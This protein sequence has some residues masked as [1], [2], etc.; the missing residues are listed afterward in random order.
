MYS[1]IP[2]N[3]SHLQHAL[4]RFTEEE[5]ASLDFRVITHSKNA[6]E[7]DE[8]WLPFLAW[9]RS[10]ADAEGWRFAETET[11][12]RNLI[13]NYIEIH[14]GKGTPAVIRQLFRDL[15]LGEIDII[16]RVADLTWSG[17][18]TF[19]GKHIFGGQGGDWAYYGVVLKRVITIQQAEL[20]KNILNEIAPTRC[21]L[22]YL[23]FR[24][25]ALLWD[26]EI[27]FSGNFTFG[28]A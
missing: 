3:N 24:D 19:D 9:E 22:L 18:V 27:D 4:A 20:L 21:K 23:D 10:I 11:A 28:A 1:I 13:R 15:K 6:D 8:K 26:G 25:T 16:E 7:C 17:E 5:L 12:Q 2:S 14:Q